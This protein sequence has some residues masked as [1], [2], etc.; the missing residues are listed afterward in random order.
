MDEKTLFELRKNNFETMFYLSMSDRCFFLRYIFDADFLHDFLIA[1]SQEI[2]SKSW[3]E[4]SFFQPLKE[5]S[6]IIWFNMLHHGGLRKNDFVVEKLGGEENTNIFVDSL[7]LS[8][9]ISCIEHK[10][11]ACIEEYYN[12]DYDS[13]HIGSFNK[14]FQ[15]FDVVKCYHLFDHPV[16]LYH[17]VYQDLRFKI[18]KNYKVPFHLC[19]ENNYSFSNE[20][21]KIVSSNFFNY[22]FKRADSR[23][24]LDFV[25]QYNDFFNID[26]VKIKIMR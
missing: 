22:D 15:D 7:E 6:M 18:L 11:A 25:N 21:I 26:E 24:I 10:N 9:K 13:S 3:I 1:R 2:F 23:G 12:M 20:E 8:L 16:E 17:K 5:E 4:I 19:L 14:G